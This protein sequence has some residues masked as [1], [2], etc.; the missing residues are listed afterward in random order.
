M[1]KSFAYWCKKKVSLISKGRLGLYSDG[2]LEI[3]GAYECNFRVH[4]AKEPPS[5]QSRSE[6]SWPLSSQSAPCY[7]GRS[8]NNRSPIASASA[9]LATLWYCIHN[10][11]EFSLAIVHGDMLVHPMHR[12][13][14]LHLHRVDLGTALHQINLDAACIMQKIEVWLKD[15]CNAIPSMRGNWNTDRRDLQDTGESSRPE[16]V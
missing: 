1:W 9:R 8:V 15:G 4:I 5:S 13:L 11:I 10:Q 7:I 6:T 2:R 16:I 3:S 12:M 14:T